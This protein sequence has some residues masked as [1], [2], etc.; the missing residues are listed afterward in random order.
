[1][2]EMSLAATIQRFAAERPAQTALSFLAA[3]GV[4]LQA[5][6]YAQL[7]EAARVAA[8]HIRA[9]RTTDAPVLL[10]TRT[11]AHCV[12][13]LCGCLYAGVAFA[14]VPIPGRGSGPRRLTPFATALGADLVLAPLDTRPLIETLPTAK[15][16]TY[17]DFSTPGEIASH[18]E[19]DDH[20]RPVLVQFTSGSTAEPKGVVL[21]N[22]NIVANLEMLRTAFSVTDADRYASWLP[23]FHD[24]GLAMLLMP[25]YFGVPGALLSPMAFLRRPARWLEI[26]DR[27]GATITG[28][29]NFAYDL[30]TSRITAEEASGLELDRCRIAFCGAE[31]VRRTTMAAFADRFAPNGFAATSLYPC[32]GLAE[33]VTFVAGGFLS[34]T[35]EDG[36]QEA[37]SCGSP[38]AGS[39]IVIVDPETGAPRTDGDVGEV[40]VAGPHIA[41]GYLNRPE[42]SRAQFAATLPGRAGQ[43]FLRTGDLGTMIAGELTITGRMKDII[44]HRGENIHAVDVEAAVAVSHPDLSPLAAAFGCV[45]DGQECLVIVQE[46]ARGAVLPDARALRHAAEDA[47]ALSFGMKLHDHLVVRTG[48][49]PK[50]TSGKIRRDE[51]RKLYLAGL[52]GG[53]TAAGA[54]PG[55]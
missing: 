12:A 2:A 48:T 52:I 9:E 43:T 42:E 39:T 49:I 4:T 55:G 29:P 22:A 11:D 16:L 7:D 45:I 32:Y 18:Q 20:T 28:A 50:T 19:P 13:A 21:T 30:C 15:W 41:A 37:V 24:M 23:L 53:T 17:D 54:T 14:P 47:V 33:A 27:V 1:M 3:D 46:L 31:P 38:A 5:V 6:S 8:H 44:I 10:L 51:T 34:S 36:L 35:R 26:V 40:W 25:L